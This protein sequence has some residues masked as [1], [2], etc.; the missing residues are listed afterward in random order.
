MDVFLFYLL[1]V[2][3]DLI[4]SL[5][6]TTALDTYQGSTKEFHE[7]GLYS[8]L[9]FGPI[10]SERRETTFS[11]IDVGIG[12]ISP[13][14]AMT[15]YEL[16]HLYKDILAGQK[17]AVWNP[18]TKDF[19][20]AAPT[21]PGANTGY[22]FFMSHYNELTPAPNQSQL[23]QQNIDLFNKY[24]EVAVSRYV[25]VVPAGIRDLE[26]VDGDRDREIDINPLY[27]KLISISRAVPNIGGG[28]SAA[29]DT[30]RWA[31]QRAFEEIY[32]YWFD[33]LDGKKGF[34]RGKF[35]QRRLFNGTRNV[36][37]PMDPSST[38]VDRADEIRPTDTIL[39]LFQ[40]LKSILPVA[41]HA[42]RTRY[43]PML[44]GADGL[45]YL[46]DKKTFRRE[47]VFVH[48]K[49]YDRFATDEGVERLIESF[50]DPHI[51]HKPI[52][53]HGRYLALIYNDGRCFKIF[54]NIQDLPDDRNRKYVRPLTYAEL[55][56][57]SGYDVWNNYFTVVTRYPVAGQGSTY[58][59][60][61]RL[62]TTAK[63]KCLYELEDDWVT[64]KDQP[65][66]DFPIRCLDEFVSTMS[67][68][69][70]RLADMQ[71]DH[72]GDTCS[73]DSAYTDEALQENR[74]KTKEITFWVSSAKKLN[75]DINVDTIKRT[76]HNLLADP[77][78]EEL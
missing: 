58:A 77:N 52:E 39:G 45:M 72:D 20:T 56:Y 13:A 76:V 34:A 38:V 30:T 59:S 21:D 6:P 73:A 75:V 62:T 68:H 15:L 69:P 46:V 48:P 49:E 66:T 43:L 36:I 24:R 44:L 14:I 51:R 61:I 19:E 10:G 55:L 26:V 47:S 63:V 12:I 31:I 57:L 5:R 41:I 11:Y 4:R 27:R 8:T 2:N 28:N 3:K 54:Y 71:A 25:L 18:K 40:G 29:M 16:K 67:P 64:R 78:E 50:R 7:D 37:S 65:A 22:A 17:Y 9:T 35:A 1:N 53:V 33:L 23:R 70:S 42:I 32:Q 60:T 74:Q